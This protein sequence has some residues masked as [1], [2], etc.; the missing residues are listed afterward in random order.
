MPPQDL[1]SEEGKLYSSGEIPKGADQQF[2]LSPEELLAL[3]RRTH[4]LT[5]ERGHIDPIS[6]GD[7]SAGEPGGAPGAGAGGGD[8]L[9]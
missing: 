6:L 9:G 7:P 8:L 4:P 3:E 5:C 1:D 2:K